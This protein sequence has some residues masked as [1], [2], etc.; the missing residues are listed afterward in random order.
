MRI[1]PRTPWPGLVL[2][3]AALAAPPAPGQVVLY[4]TGFEPPA[5]APGPLA[6][7][8]GWGTPFGPSAVVV[9]TTQPSAGT[10]AVQINGSGVVSLGA[11]TGLAGALSVRS[12]NYTA[13]AT[14]VVDIR[15]RGRLSGPSTNTGQGADDDL[16]SLNLAAA[17]TNNRSLGEIE[18]SSAGQAW[19]FDPLGNYVFGTPIT[20][21]TDFEL[22]IRLDFTARTTQYLLN[23]NVLG[24]V[25]FDTAITGNV[26]SFAS[27]G[28]L[29][30]DDPA[31][32]DSS[33][34]TGAFDNLTVTVTPVPEPG[35]LALVGVAAVAGLGAR[36]R[37]AG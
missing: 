36:R 28:L 27:L 21:G 2:T 31:T 12:F 4:Q 18:L 25:P 13:T 24:S 22:G 16:V 19:G 11:G 6:G 10:Q 23:D 15:A 30:V 9:S 35:S 14:P 17:T 26:L 8:D 7:Q 37:R 5:Y 33:L 1:I 29:A 20:L 3:L 34:Y 32:V